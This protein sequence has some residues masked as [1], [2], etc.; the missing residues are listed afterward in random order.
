MRGK[1]RPDNERLLLVEMAKGLE[2]DTAIYVK[3][4]GTLVIT[5]PGEVTEEVP[6]ILSKPHQIWY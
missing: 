1:N 4:D 2:D 3:G 5:D 6:L